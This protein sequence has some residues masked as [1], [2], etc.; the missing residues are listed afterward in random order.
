M[1]CSLVGFPAYWRNLV[2]TYGVQVVW[3]H[4]TGQSVGS[5]LPN[6]AVSYHRTSKVPIFLA[7][8]TSD[9]TY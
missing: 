8:R 7:L 6:Y 1:S 3:K 4:H 9:L 2:S 5:L